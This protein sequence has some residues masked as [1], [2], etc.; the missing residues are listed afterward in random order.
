MHILYTNHSAGLEWGS[1]WRKG[2][3]GPTSIPRAPSPYSPLAH[4]VR[5][6]VAP[7]SL[8]MDGPETLPLWTHGVTATP[9]EIHYT[10][11]LIALLL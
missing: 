10:I 1:S 6:T 7:T 9:A 5:V 11:T 4:P 3:G 8:L 2:G